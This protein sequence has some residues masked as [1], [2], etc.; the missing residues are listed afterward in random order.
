MVSKTLLHTFQHWNWLTVKQV[1][2]LGSCCI[3]QVRQ[4][5]WREKE[6]VDL[7]L[8]LLRAFERFL[9]SIQ[10]PIKPC[11]LLLILLWDLGVVIID[12]ENTFWV[13]ESVGI[14]WECEDGKMAIK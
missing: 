5:Q 12:I 14:S 6:L 11:T 3:Q 10:S 13:V 4:L 7:S 9:V 8:E 1:N 2:G